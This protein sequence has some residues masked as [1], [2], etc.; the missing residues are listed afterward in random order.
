MRAR[1]LGPAALLLPLVGCDLAA[2]LGRPPDPVELVPPAILSLEW[3]CDVDEDAWRLVVETDAWT[4]GGNLWLSPDAE[5]VESHPVRSVRAAAD[6]TSDRLRLDL[7]VASDW[8]DVAPG[9]S[10]AVGCGEDAA[11]VLV[12]ND[13]DSAVSDCRYGGDVALMALDGIPDC[14]SPVDESL[15]QVEG[16][17]QARRVR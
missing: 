13:T 5:Y 6:G 1:R 7:A 12:V 15:R 17:L 14:D 4:G 3:T 11:W 2:P 16:G 8:R 9:S 10:T